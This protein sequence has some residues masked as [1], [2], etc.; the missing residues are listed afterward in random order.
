M[1]YAPAEDL[2]AI[3][4]APSTVDA[5]LES[6]Y[7]SA[8]IYFPFTDLIVTDPYGDMAPGLKHAYYVG[9]SKI[10][11][12]VTTDIVAFAGNGI[13]VEMWVGAEDKLPRHFCQNSFFARRHIISLTER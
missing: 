9:Q 4:D 13:F 12:G 11:A 8:G 5:T 2:I 6:V 10:V 3:A 1:A 7:H